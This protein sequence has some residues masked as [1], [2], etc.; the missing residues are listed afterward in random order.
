MSE[1]DT[2]PTAGGAVTD[3]A[4]AG[5]AG[6]LP[7]DA[8]DDVQDNDV[9]DN[10]VQDNDVQDDADSDL[11]DDRDDN[12]LDDD[13]EGIDDEGIDDANRILGGRATA[14]LTYLARQIVDDPDGVTVEAS[15]DRGVV[16]LEL[17]VSPGDMGKVIGRKGRVAQAIRAIVR[18][19]AAQE[20]ISVFVDI[21]D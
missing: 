11:D 16:R 7:G 17:F 4:S 21:V 12:D 5:L 9:Q 19:A 1:G 14:V 10:D 18:A 13:D 8:D 3:P 2:A 15:Q 20:G 6:G